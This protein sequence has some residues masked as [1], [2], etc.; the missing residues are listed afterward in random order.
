MVVHT[1][2][3]GS[4]TRIRLSNRFGDKPLAVGHATLGLPWADGGPGDLQPGSIKDATFSGQLGV[5]IPA[6]GQAVSDPID[7]PVGAAADVAVSI[8]LPEPTGPAT[9][10]LYARQT[11]YIGAGDHAA[12]ATGADLPDTTSS[13]FYLTGLDVLNDSGQGSVAVI[14]D[15]ITD[16]FAAP[17]NANQRWTNRLAARLNREAPGGRAPGVLNLG[18][19]GNRLGHNGADVGFPELGVNASAR[20]SADVLAQAGVHT[21]LLQLGINDVWLGRE[22]ANTIIAEMQQLA[23]LAHQ[24]GLR[25]F[26][27]TLMP[28]NGFAAAPGATTYTPTL[29]SVRLAVNSYIRTNTDFDGIIDLDGAMRDPAS[30][31]RLRPAWDSGDH[32]HPNAEG[33][34]AMANAVPLVL[35]LHGADGA[36]ME[37]NRRAVAVS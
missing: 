2:V 20:F 14:G 23:G 13:W 30:P 29:D 35:L 4:Q 28:W 25:I 26:V 15:S 33:N 3:G 1:S 11:T 27:C 37:S 6:G 7:V 5:T 18:L 17:I 21:V 9:W 24:A 31:T 32:I 12:A 10:H 22:N 19:A 16:G 34:E 36:D 8:Y